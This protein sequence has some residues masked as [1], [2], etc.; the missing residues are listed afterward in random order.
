MAARVKVRAV[1]WVDGRVVV[2]RHHR[3]GELHTTLPGGWVNDRESVTDALIREVREEL[4]LDIAVGDL[5]MAAEVVNSTS[6]QDVELIFSA[7]L[8]RQPEPS[9]LVL[10]DPGSLEAAQVLPPVLSALAQMESSNGSADGRWLG[11][12]YRPRGG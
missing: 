7:E 5:L 10:V 6:L 8:L 4:G 11:N 1:I 12:I 9:E 3:R 2:H